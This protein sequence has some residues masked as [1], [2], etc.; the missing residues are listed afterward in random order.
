MESY[1]LKEGYTY[2]HRWKKK[3]MDRLVSAR[4]AIREYA[5][6]KNYDYLLFID[7]DIIAPPNTLTKL[8]SDKKDIITALCIILNQPN[9]NPI[10]SAKIYKDGLYYAFPADKIDGDLYE[11]DLIG[12][13][14]VLISKKIL[15]RFKIVCERDESGKL[16][17]SEDC[18][19]SED[20][21]KANIPIYFDTS[22]KTIHKVS[23]HGHWNFDT[24]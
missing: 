14:C 17:K 19:F 21:K 6:K 5:I 23:G 3:A 20:L 2:L 15:K 8:I 10:P 1:I 11:V 22:I 7:A 16:Y 9:G 18:C 24:A 12:F 13:G 4:N